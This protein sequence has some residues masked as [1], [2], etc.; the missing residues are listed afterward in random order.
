[1]AEV[2]KTLIPITVSASLLTK[3]WPE[4]KIDFYSKADYWWPN[5]DDQMGPYIRT[6]G[7]DQSG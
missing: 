1:M 6:Y 2:L 3:K 5:P 4:E 7:L